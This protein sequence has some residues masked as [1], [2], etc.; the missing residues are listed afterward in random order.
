MGFSHFSLEE[1][2]YTYEK[3]EGQTEPRVLIYI[4]SNCP[5]KGPKTH[6]NPV[7][8][9]TSRTQNMFSKSNYQLKG[10]THS[11]KRQ[12]TDKTIVEKNKVGDLH[13]HI[14]KCITKQW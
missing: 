12:Q 13:F 8:M 1:D 2:P 9:S 3:E 7:A 11:C 4:H 10:I 6:N 5:L 14:L